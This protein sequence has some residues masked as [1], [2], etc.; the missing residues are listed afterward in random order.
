MMPSVMVS[1]C[2]MGHSVRYD[3]GHKAHARVQA[4]HRLGWVTSQPCP[5]VEAGLPV[6]R[7][8]IDLIEINHGFSVVER[9]TGRH[10][11]PSIDAVAHRHIQAH[12]ESPLDGFI[13]KSKSPSCAVGSAPVQNGPQVKGTTDGRFSK[14]SAQ[15]IRLVYELTSAFWTTLSVG[16]SSSDL[17]ISTGLIVRWR[18]MRRAVGCFC[19]PHDFGSF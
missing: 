16:L 3:G 10:L 14:Y 6:P 19:L 15:L 12:S 11:T 17:Y 8:P 2:L 4:L 9:G 1:R 18:S 7:N 13:F 5:E